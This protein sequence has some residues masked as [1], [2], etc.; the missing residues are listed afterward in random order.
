MSTPHDR[1]LD[2]LTPL[3]DALVEH[4]L[5]PSVRTI[6][7]LAVFTEHHVFA[8]WD[9]M[10]LLKSLQRRLTCVELPW[11]PTGDPETRRLIN[12]IV[13][14]EESDE[15]PEGGYTSHFELYRDAM[16]RCGGKTTAVDALVDALGRGASIDA[17]LAEAGAPHAAAAHA[18][19]TWRIA[20]SAPDHVVAAVFTYGREDLIPGMFTSVVR[21]LGD[22]MPE[23]AGRLRYYLDRHVEVDGGHHGVLARRMVERLCGDDATRWREAEHASA[24]ALVARRALWDGTLSAIARRRALPAA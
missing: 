7:D 14:G 4:P 1:L 18:R 21:A 12:E 11:R 3:R 6:D 23:R 2:A 22:A 24:D 15:D 17:A 20:K 19:L 10:L 13:V 8:V 16:R 9:F 5:Y